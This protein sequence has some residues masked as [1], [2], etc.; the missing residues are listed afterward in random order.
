VASIITHFFSMSAALAEKVFMLDPET[1]RRTAGPAKVARMY[2][3]GSNTV[4][5][6]GELFFYIKQ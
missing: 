2:P 4:N 6:L 1:R 3:V 5:G